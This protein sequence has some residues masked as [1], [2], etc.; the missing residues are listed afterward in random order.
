MVQAFLESG[1]LLSQ[2][3]VCWTTCFVAPALDVFFH[4]SRD[5][6]LLLIVCVRDC[7]SLRWPEEGGRFSEAGVTCSCELPNMGGN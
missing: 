3:S 7:M 4:F 5:F 6:I 2:P 1:V